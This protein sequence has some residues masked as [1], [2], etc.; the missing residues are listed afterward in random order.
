VVEK[1]KLALRRGRLR[2]KSEGERKSGC[3]RKFLL[4]GKKLSKR[5]GHRLG[6]GGLGTQTGFFGSES[7]I[8]EGAPSFTNGNSPFEMCD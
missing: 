5:G 2:G 7:S 4:P 1:K 3:G 6:G 8:T